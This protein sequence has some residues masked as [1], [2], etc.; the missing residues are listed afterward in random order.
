MFK[1]ALNLSKLSQEEI[2][3]SLHA[4]INTDN[5]IKEEALDES[6]RRARTLT[7]YITFTAT[8]SAINERMLHVILCR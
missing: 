3:I 2:D 1:I 6:E 4:G 8:N 5:L 7:E